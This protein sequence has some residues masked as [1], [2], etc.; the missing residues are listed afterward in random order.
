MRWIAGLLLALLAV[1]NA[2][3]DDFKSGGFSFRTG[4]PPSFV[5]ERPLPV[6]W[7]ADAPGASDDQW[8]YWRYDVQADRR[9]GGDVTYTDYAYEARSQGNVADAGRFEITYNPDYQA[10]TLH[11]VELRRNGVWHTRFKPSDISIA[12]R[13]RQFEQD[14][15]DGQ[16]AALIVIEDVRVG[17]IVR[18]SWSVAGSNPI[19]AGQSSEQIRLAYSHPILDARLRTL[20]PPATAIATHLENGAPPPRITQRADA[21]V[22]EAGIVRADR[23]EDEGDYPVWYQPYPLVQFAPR[24]SWGDVV[25]WALPLYPD[26]STTALPDDLE[27][28]LIAWKAISTA[29]GRLRAALRAVQD[30]VRYFGVETG[31]SSHKPRPPALVWSRRYGDCK[32]KAWLLVTLL[33]R[34]GVKAEP[35]LV[36]TVRGKSLRDYAPAADLFNHVIVRATIDDKPVFMDPTLRLQGGDPASGDLSRYGAVLPVLAGNMRTTDISPPPSPAAGVDVKERY[37][38]DGAGMRLD[39]STEYRAANADK[40]RAALDGERLEEVSKRYRE[41]YAKRFG[42]VETLQALA[43]RDDRDANILVVQEAYRLASPWQ[44]EGTLRGL[45]MQAQA[46]AGVADMPARSDRR[47]PLYF[48][49]P[50]RYLQE[51]VVEAPKGWSARFVREDDRVATDAMTYRRTLEASE[52][53]AILRHELD[54]AVRDVPLPAVP[55]HINALRKIGDGFNSRL[56]Y[57]APASADAGE[58]QSRL[59]NLLRDV[60]KDQ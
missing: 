51:V 46:L 17:D 1:P 3:A 8:R 11:R 24:R 55:S 5:D 53:V 7:P 26:Q 35:V 16:V 59:Q 44:Q 48:A 6:D 29:S 18:I 40:I 45:D 33:Q 19:L 31:T 21:T 36:D 27:Q 43:V 39:V 38:P 9:E 47:A 20:Y 58:R 15:S 50:G 56:R 14:I 13:E 42:A 4:S 54:V 60:M 32:D 37:R 49:R 57:A 52:G 23:L 12:R 10:L 30:E 25:R 22:V 41:Y 34:L 2:W 28:R